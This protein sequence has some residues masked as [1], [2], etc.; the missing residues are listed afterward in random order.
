MMRVTELVDGL[1]GMF[2]EVPGAVEFGDAPL[3]G[4]HARAGWL[5]LA[6][7]AGSLRSRRS[8]RDSDAPHDPIVYSGGV[9]QN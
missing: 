4:S 2:L 8:R 9:I 7:S 1:R 5:G 3:F 6:G